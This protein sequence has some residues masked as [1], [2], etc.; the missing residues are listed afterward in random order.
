MKKQP[1]LKKC[2]LRINAIG[3]EKSQQ[4]LG[5]STAYEGQAYDIMLHAWIGRVTGWLS[6]ASLGVSMFDWLSHLAISPAKQ[7]NLLQQ[8]FDSWLQC[9]LQ[10][11]LYLHHGGCPDLHVAEPRPDDNRFKDKMWEDFPF[12]LYSQAFLL[13]ERWWDTATTSIRGVS[14]HH[15]HVVNFLARQYLDM[16]S[17]SNFPTTNPE[18]LYA[19]AQQGGMNFLTGYNNMM[20]DLCRLLHKQPPVGTEN[21]P[22][23]ERVAVTP[24]KVIYRNRLIELIQYKPTTPTVYAEPILIVPAWI[25][26]YYILDLSPHNS[27]VKYL[28]E[29]GHTVF[30]ISW[31]N[32]TSDDRNLGLEDYLNLGIMSAIEVINHIVPKKKIH[33]T[34]YC[35]GGTLLTI[36]AATMAAYGDDRLKTVTLFA[37]QVDFREPG[38]LSLFIDPSQVTYLEDVMWEKGYLDGSQMSWAFSML[39]SNDLVWSRIIH[40]YLLGN[41]R[42]INDLMAWDYDTTRLPFAMHS[43]YLRELFLNNELVQGRYKVGKKKIALLDI[44]TPIFSVATVKDHVSPWRSVYKIQ[45][46]TDTNVTFVLTSGGHNAGIVSEPGHR[47]RTYQMQTRKSGDKHVSSETWLETAHQHQGSWWPA[48]QKWLEAHSSSEKIAKPSMGNPDQEI[49][50]LCD[51]PGTYVLEK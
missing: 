23:G 31:K 39:R 13:H 15:E 32:P 9:V 21:F 8:A 14:K 20:E 26:K 29:H 11:E 36:A 25:M 7:F 33:A 43:E 45:L 46:Y 3:N 1:R 24:G 30:M 6:P 17:P 42:P 38:A 34:G 27:L 48:W 44:T 16:L 41:R 28:V 47:G 22:V 19:T 10:I 4:P 40:D 35:L 50:V 5:L 2:K 12:N 51:A 49:T 37:A 18:V